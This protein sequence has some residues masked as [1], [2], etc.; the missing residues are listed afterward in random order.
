MQYHKFSNFEFSFHKTLYHPIQIFLEF[1]KKIKTMS[2]SFVSSVLKVRDS[3]GG[4]FYLFNFILDLKEMNSFRNPP[5]DEGI[6]MPFK[7]SHYVSPSKSEVEKGLK[8]LT[9]PT[10][11][12]N[13]REFDVL[14]LGNKKKLKYS[15]S[16]DII[17]KWLKKKKT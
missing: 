13:C 14:S 3:M 8:I 7:Y 4:S 12:L 15:E 1:P 2:F 17:Y 5:I 16:R 6:E 10:K 11:V 9:M